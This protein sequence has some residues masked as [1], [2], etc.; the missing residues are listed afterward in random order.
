MSDGGKTRLSSSKATA[1]PKAGSKASSKSGPKGNKR[2]FIQKDG[3]VKRLKIDT[4]SSLCN[5]DLCGLS[6]EDFSAVCVCVC[7]QRAIEHMLESACHFILPTNGR[8]WI[9]SCFGSRWD[10]GEL[11]WEYVCVRP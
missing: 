3:G 8:V 1:K 7:V 9:S 10:F 5:C 4:T 6:S 2:D 11:L